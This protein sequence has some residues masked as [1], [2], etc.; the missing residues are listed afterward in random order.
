MK[1]SIFLYLTLAFTTFASLG[2]SKETR[3]LSSF[4]SISVGE[5]IDVIIRK[6]TTESAIVEVSG[7]DLD[8]VLTE[9]TGNRI[10]IGMR[11]S[12]KGYRN[13]RVRVDLTYV[14]IDRINVSSAADLVTKGPIET[15]NLD[16]DVSSAGDARLEVNVRELEV[17]VSQAGD[18]EIKGQ[19]D[20]QRV[21]VSSAGDYDAFDL[22]SNSAR[23]D[24]SGAG[25]AR[26]NVTDDLDADASSGGSIY[27]RGDPDK[28]YTDA[29][30]G[31]KVKKY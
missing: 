14:E 30:S 3:S 27:Y 26:V 28:V 1:N 24:V 29:S 18:L 2:Q 25:D 8:D 20:R 31:G 21:R 10:K 19:A 7:A 5:A 17:Q 6:G 4:S 22:K 11:S 23:V 13:V 16:V 15:D 9:V 12:L